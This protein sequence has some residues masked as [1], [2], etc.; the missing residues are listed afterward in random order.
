VIDGGCGYLIKEEI[1]FMK[2]CDYGCGQEAKHQFKNSKWCCSKSHN[3]CPSM[4]K[5]NSL[6]LI[7][8]NKGRVLSKNTKMKMSMSKKGLQVGEKSPTWRGGYNERNIPLFDQYA[9][10]LIP[11]EKVNR[12]HKDKNI[13]E[14][15]CTYCGKYYIP[16]LHTVIDRIRS[17]NSIGYGEHRFYCSN[18]C[19]QECSIYNQHY[20]PKDF[21]PATSREVQPELRQIRFE[22]DNYTCQRCKKHQNK[23]KV[24]LHC[25]HLEGIR[26]EPLESA[27]VDKVITLCKDCHIEVHKLEDCSYNDMKCK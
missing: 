19:K 17:I 14:V 26:W 9:N 21:K 15:Q 16:K 4:K 6:K 18:K 7:G 23:L 12:N 20:Y 3:S 8:K 5:I 10:Q 11:I 25:H 24:G 2:L 13:L 22:I 27:D 1:Y